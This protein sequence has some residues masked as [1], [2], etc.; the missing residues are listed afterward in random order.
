VGDIPRYL[1]SLATQFS[2]CGTDVVAQA[3]LARPYLYAV[4]TKRERWSS[5][6]ATMVPGLYLASRV[7]RT[8]RDRVMYVSVV[9]G[10]RRRRRRGQS[11]SLVYAEHVKSPHANQVPGHAFISY[12]HEDSALVDR[13]QRILEAAGIRVWR[14]TADLWPGQDW[15]MEIR[16][17][18]KS[19]SLAFIAC[20]SPNSQQRIESYQNEELLL[21]VEQ[22]RLRKPGQPW[23]I[24]VRFGN[25]ETPEFDLGAGRTLGSLQHVDLFDGFWERGTAR[26]VASVLRILVES[27]EGLHESS[28]AASNTG[29]WR[30]DDA[31]SV[32]V[33][34]AQLPIDMLPPFANPSHPDYSEVYRFAELGS[35]FELYGHL[36]AT[37][38]SIQ[39]DVLD[40]P[41]LSPPYFASHLIALGGFSWNSV[42]L[43]ILN[44]LSL[45]VMQVVDREMPGTGFF[46]V[47]ENGYEK[48]LLP[49]FRQSNG[50]EILRED[51]AL[52]VRAASPF[53]GRRTVSICTGMYAAG[54]FG[55]VRALTDP[56]FRDRNAEYLARRFSDSDSFCIL[57]RV[58]VEYG[59][60]LTPDWTLSDS[61]LFEW[62]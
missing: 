46:A 36:R 20:F 25:C 56:G 10:V 26:L 54:T 61:L 7:V 18:I 21:A 58:Q 12:V 57:S 6:A 38:P 55:A 40:P 42:T 17:A 39:V 47:Q 35:L 15:K 19:N 49:V 4:D 1:D 37:N 8:R 2:G 59:V 50:T 45:P 31:E 52:F 24:P 33:V 34:C 48:R 9:S 62:P 13:L 53:N 16:R 23:L 5:V 29:P 27:I 41:R 60:V 44:R 3:L 22:M 43:A 11:G 14:D 32:T 28:E 30:F 51:V